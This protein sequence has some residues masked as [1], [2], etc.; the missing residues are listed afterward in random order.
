MF[1]LQL[2]EHPRSRHSS[3][4][5]RHNSRGI[6]RPAGDV[7]RRQVGGY[8]E[9]A[10]STGGRSVITACLGGLSYDTGRP[11]KGK[12]VAMD[13]GSAEADAGVWADSSGAHVTKPRSW[14]VPGVPQSRTYD[15]G[16]D[17]EHPGSEVYFPPVPNGLD[18]L[19]SV[20]EHLEAEPSGSA[21]GT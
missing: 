8:R 11:L 14:R 4:S 17:I 21:P 19:L 5:T 10:L 2:G 16:R 7:D 12:P 9:G 6:P 15:P 13:P 1:V 18:Y 3:P 20:V